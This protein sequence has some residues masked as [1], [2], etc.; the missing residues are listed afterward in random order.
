MDEPGF[1][2]R[3]VTWHFGSGDSLF[4][5]LVLLLLAVG[6]QAR[7]GS[8]SR[9]LMLAILSIVWMSLGSWPSFTMYWLLLLVTVAWLSATMKGY[10]GSLPGWRRTVIVV[11]LFAGVKEVPHEIA[12]DSHLADAQSVSIIGDSVTAGLNAG[13]ITWP[14]RLAN[15]IGRTVYDASQQGAT[16]KSALS[17]LEKLDGRGEVLWIEIGGNDILESLSSDVYAERL[18]Q[19]LNAATQRYQKIVLMEIPAPPGGGRYGFH[20]RRLASKYRLSLVP[21]RQ[22]LSVLT[23]SGGTQDGVHLANPGHQRMA[24]VVQTNL[25]WKIVDTAKDHG[26]YIRCE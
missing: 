10:S 12:K 9:V 8:S 1:L 6:W 23:S 19:L 26:H 2:L 3:A 17:Q 13:D 4:T 11:T 14:W 25:G 5:A 18:D 22:F 24:S 7:G 15:R 20:Q 16:V 21:K